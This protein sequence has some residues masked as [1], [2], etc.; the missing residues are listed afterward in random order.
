M[1][2]M[3]MGRDGTPEQGMEVHCL[4]GCG[5]LAVGPRDLV[6]RG[7]AIHFHVVH[8]IGVLVE[9]EHYSM[10]VAPYRCDLCGGVAEPPWWTHVCDP[11]LEEAGD[12]DGRWLVCDDCHAL[13]EVHD[14]RRLLDRAANAQCAQSNKVTKSMVRRHARPKFELFLARVQPEAVRDSNYR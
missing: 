13:V 9:G 11:P 14:L 4:L 2:D 10:G 3:Q 5:L 1:P 12:L 7:V 8:G 6:L